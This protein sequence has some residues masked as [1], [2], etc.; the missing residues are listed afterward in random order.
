MV[1][2]L[3]LD[4]LVKVRVLVPQLSQVSEYAA[5]TIHGLFK[6]LLVIARLVLCLSFSEIDPG[7]KSIIEHWPKLSVELRSAIVKMVR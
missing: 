1:A 5:L 7:L 3:T 4:Q 6:P 2:R